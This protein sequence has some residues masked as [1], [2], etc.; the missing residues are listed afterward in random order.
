VV[1]SKFYFVG[2][3]IAA[4][5]GA[6]YLIRDGGIAGSDIVLFEESGDFGGALDAH[7]NAETGYFMSGSRMFEN[8]YNC[9]FDLLSGIPSASNPAISVTAETNRVAVENSWN[10]KAR[11]VDLHGNITDFHRLGFSERDRADIL[12]LLVT[13]ERMLDARR[14]TDC[15]V[16]SFFQTTFWYEWCTLFAFQPW[17]SAIEFKRYLLRFIHH[18]S[19]IDTQEGVYRTRFNQYESIAMPVVSWLRERGVQIRL[20]TSVRD[21][22]FAKTTNKRITVDALEIAMNGQGTTLALD[23]KDF[24]F[25]TNGSMTADKAFGSMSKAPVLDR[26]KQSGAWRLWETLAADRPEFGNPAAFDAHIDESVWESFSVTTSGPLFLKRIQDFT[27][28]VPGRGGLTTFKDSNWL[29]TLSIFHQPFFANQP[30]NV[31]V[32]WGYGLYYDQPGNYVDKP[33]SACTGREILEE[34]LGHLHFDEDKAAIIAA[35]NVIPCVMPYITSQFLVRKAGDRPSVVPK[36][37]TN[38]AFIGQ[39]AELP[40]DVVFT[41]EYSIRSAQTAVYELL[42]LDR[43]PTPMYKGAHDPRVV[44]AALE[45]LHR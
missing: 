35:S 5:A 30:E 34:V 24:V 38:L 19:T 10:D 42:S 12:T 43:K 8:K 11:L 4:L 40:D 7:G 21:L 2:S 37:S 20:G 36:G 33:M 15:F 9:T 3:G 44:F 16:P 31:A 26:S 13:P 41:V 39:Y 32:W 14:I 25:V 22:R 27:G 29:I 6:V 45:T 17:H 1:L 18:F 28:S 23:E